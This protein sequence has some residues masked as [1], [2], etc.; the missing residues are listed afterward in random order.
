MSSYLGGIQFGLPLG[1]VSLD[2]FLRNGTG[3]LA[4]AQT[5]CSSRLFLAKV[6]E[7]LSFAL[8]CRMHRDTGVIQVFRSAGALWSI[9]QFWMAFELHGGGPVVPH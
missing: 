7:A 6:K 8:I 1:I 4:F 3:T 9:E 5:R 2:S